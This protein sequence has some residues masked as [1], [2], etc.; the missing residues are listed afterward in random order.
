M[1]LVKYASIELRSEKQPEGQSKGAKTKTSY[2]ISG[3][4]VGMTY[5]ASCD[6]MHSKECM[7]G[8]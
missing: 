7:L 1:E 5:L 6:A 8:V 3:L 2:A 4:R